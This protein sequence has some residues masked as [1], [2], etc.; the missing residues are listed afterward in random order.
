[1]S[2]E[3]EKISF[4]KKESAEIGHALAAGMAAIEFLQEVTVALELD[5]KSSTIDTIIARIVDLV[6]T[7]KAFIAQVKAQK[8][9]KL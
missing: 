9:S 3:K 7:E 4:D 1:M 5:P 6:S 8:A 2:E